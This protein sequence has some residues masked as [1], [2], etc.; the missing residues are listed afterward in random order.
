MLKY[1]C[2]PH[3][4]TSKKGHDVIWRLELRFPSDLLQEQKQGQTFII[5][6][7]YYNPNGKSSGVSNVLTRTAVK[8]RLCCWERDADMCTQRACTDVHHLWNC[9]GRSLWL[10]S[11]TNAASVFV[12]VMVSSLWRICNLPHTLLENPWVKHIYIYLP[13]ASLHLVIG[14]G[15]KGRTTSGL[16]RLK[17]KSRS[18]RQD[19]LTEYVMISNW[20]NRWTGTEDQR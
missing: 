4:D 17:D 5:K 14:A 12:G 9:R 3:H 19:E 20:E 13:Q 6:H 18:E 1:I 11:E 15:H 8:Q 16:A 2:P 7:P 10:H